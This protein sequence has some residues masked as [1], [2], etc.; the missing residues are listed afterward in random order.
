M[1]QI[2][3]Q[4]VISW[5]EQWSSQNIHGFRPSHSGKDVWWPTAVKIELALLNG[6]EISG[7][8]LDYSKRF[9]RIPIEIAFTI[10]KTAGLHDGTLRAMQ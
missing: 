8:S 4:T 7:I 5:Q 9:D 2:G 3:G 10:A 6:T 1:P